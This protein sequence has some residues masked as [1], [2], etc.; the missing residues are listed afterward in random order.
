MAQRAGGVAAE[1]QERT[2]PAM[3]HALAWPMLEVF[4]IKLHCPCGIGVFQLP[5]GI[6]QAAQPKG[7]IGLRD[8]FAG[9]WRQA[10]IQHHLAGVGFERHQAVADQNSA[11][12]LIK[13]DRGQGA[14]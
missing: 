2:E 5:G 1:L 11:V 10:I 7:R 6:E 14:M 4:A 12:F 8:G 9:G 13:L 3:S